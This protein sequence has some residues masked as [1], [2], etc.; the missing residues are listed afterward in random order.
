MSIVTSQQSYKHDLVDDMYDVISEEES[1]ALS[2]ISESDQ[3]YSRDY[4]DQK[5]EVIEEDEEYQ[6][7]ERRTTPIYYSKSSNEAKSE[8][9]DYVDDLESSPQPS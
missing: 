8:Y 9:D 5:K 7:I 4:S 3:K 1:E 6:E 2:H